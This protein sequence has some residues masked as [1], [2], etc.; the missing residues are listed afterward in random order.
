MFHCHGSHSSLVSRE[1]NSNFLK[2]YAKKKCKARMLCQPHKV[3]QWMWNL[4]TFQKPEAVETKNTHKMSQLAGRLYALSVHS[5]KNISVGG[6]SL[7]KVEKNYLEFSTRCLFFFKLLSY[8]CARWLDSIMSLAHTGKI[9][10][11][12]DVEA[13]PKK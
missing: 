10:Y 3:I 5:E 11:I 13:K 9:N 1:K 6:I 8:R 7:S 2:C 4:N 12:A